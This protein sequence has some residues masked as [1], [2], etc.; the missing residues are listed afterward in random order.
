ML[1]DKDGQPFCVN[2]K[3]QYL[4]KGKFEFKV[5]SAV[6]EKGTQENEDSIS[7]K[8]PPPGSHGS[9]LRIRGGGGGCTR[10][11]KSVNENAFIMSPRLI[12]ASAHKP[13]SSTCKRAAFLLLLS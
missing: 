8:R 3:L 1:K 9:Y 12:L 7:H 4:L 6:E 10:L 13:Y 11:R 2:V 5:V